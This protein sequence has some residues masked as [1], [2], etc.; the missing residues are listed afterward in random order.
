[1]PFLSRFR[2]LLRGD[3]SVVEEHPSL[4]ELDRLSAI[5]PLDVGGTHIPG[6]SDV[7]LSQSYAQ[8]VQD[9]RS[10]M[11][12]TCRWLEPADAKLIG[13]H[14]MA[15]GSFANI[16]E[17]TYDDRKVVLKSYRCYMTFSVA[18]TVAVRCN[19]NMC[20]VVCC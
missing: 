17:M 3:P 2:A 5:S 4:Q 15:A 12:P 14:P 13:G 9:L 1:M 18:Q 20:R 19:H 10:F 7:P 11:P 6:S 16:W 8:M